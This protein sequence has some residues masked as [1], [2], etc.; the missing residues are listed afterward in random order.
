M[1]I[2]ITLLSII[3]A[4][5]TLYSQD[6]NKTYIPNIARTPGPPG[7]VMTAPHMPSSEQDLMII[8]KLRQHV[9]R[10]EQQLEDCEDVNAQLIKQSEQTNLALEDAYYWV[11]EYRR[12]LHVTM[13]TGWFYH[14][15]QGWLHT[16]QQSFPYIYRNDNQSWYYF[17]RDH[18]QVDHGRAFY[19]YTTNTWEIWK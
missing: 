4:A 2:K 14:E 13:L 8:D 15:K 5:S 6:T 1:K 11:N 18:E 12:Q 16:D 9:K 19:N 3:V 17:A 7:D 10:L